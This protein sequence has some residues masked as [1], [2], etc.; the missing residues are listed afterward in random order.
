MFQ[1]PDTLP[2]A[3]PPTDRPL[4][5]SPPLHMVGHSPLVVIYDLRRWPATVTDRAP[6]EDPP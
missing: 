2:Q 1:R 3:T 5:D 6:S 4:I